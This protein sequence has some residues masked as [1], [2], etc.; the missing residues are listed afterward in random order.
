MPTLESQIRIDAP[1]EAVFDYLADFSKHPD[2]ASHPLTVE[3]ETGVAAV[4]GS[5][6]TSTAQF[7]GQHKARITVVASDRPGRLVFDV[8]DDSGRY[9]H[10]ISVR[11]DGNGSLLT[12]SVT[13]T[14]GSIVNKAL[15]R[16]LMPL[17]G[18]KIIKQDVQ[19]IKA[20]LESP[21]S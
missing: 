12:K 8:A 7:I 10:T 20:R 14:G 18:K 4:A 21:S 1:P 11:P 5:T 3:A 15:G 2:W 6:L 16:V 17:V 13:M 9:R 19:R